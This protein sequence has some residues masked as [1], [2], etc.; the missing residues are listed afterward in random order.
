MNPS[1]L[2]KL[3]SVDIEVLK[4]ALTHVFQRIGELIQDREA[5]VLDFGFAT[6][7]AENRIVDF[8]FKDVRPAGGL[9]LQLDVA[10]A[11]SPSARNALRQKYPLSPMV[12]SLNP[13]F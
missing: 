12:H 2:V 5:L 11:A 1:A 10:P 7:V 6:L 13:C 4:L 3:T 8:V 9:Q